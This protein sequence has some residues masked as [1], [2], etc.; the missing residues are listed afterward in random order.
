MRE[1]RNS[2]LTRFRIA[3]IQNHPLPAGA[4]RGKT[5]LPLQATRA[6]LLDGRAAPSLAP[7]LRGEGALRRFAS[8]RVRGRRRG[9]QVRNS[10]EPAP[11][12]LT[13]SENKYTIPLVTSVRLRDHFDE[14][15]QH[16]PRTTRTRS[17]VS[18]IA[19][20]VTSVL[21]CRSAPW[22]AGASLR[23]RHRRLPILAIA[24]SAQKTCSTDPD[25]QMREVA[26]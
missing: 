13:F 6:V 21:M 3:T 19:E 2:P 18:R 12:P 9:S 24:L 14:H 1:P 22:A 15:S 23:Q 4:G 5:S 26:I 17:T 10:A 8:R 7:L 25:G 11:P 16:A 20:R